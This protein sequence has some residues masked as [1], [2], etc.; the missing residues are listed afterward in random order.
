M[1]EETAGRC[2][3][4][5]CAVLHMQQ[6]ASMWE[7]QGEPAGC[8]GVEWGCPWRGLARARRLLLLWGAAPFRSAADPVARLLWRSASPDAA[9][10]L[11]KGG[12]LR[13]LISIALGALRQSQVAEAITTGGLAATFVRLDSLPTSANALRY[14][15]SLAS[16]EVLAMQ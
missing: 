7:A 14:R 5:L 9:R 1:R 12:V 2:N 15:G 4:G 3:A 11:I 6:L 10:M 16:A 13:T 8:P